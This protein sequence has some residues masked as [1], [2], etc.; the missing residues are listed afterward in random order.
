[1]TDR[2]ASRRGPVTTARIALVVAVAANGVIGHEGGL[3]WRVP[4]D[5]RHFRSL[6]MGKP[7]VMGRRTYQSIGGP[8]QGRD[9]I[10]V[11]RDTEF[12]PEGV[13]IA[14]SIAAALDEA[15][16]LARLRHVDEIMIIGGAMIY[17]ETLALAERLYVTEIHA[18]PA[19][20]TR[21]P[22]ID[23]AE[24]REISR[25]RF[26]AGARDDADYSLVVYERNGETE[27]D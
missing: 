11:T 13:F 25:R 8:L 26:V 3:P 4:S 9:N 5:L 2:A 27:A 18:T 1:M 10:V 12:A 15:E 20:D 22:R 6:T 7:V 24:W 17:A 21:F 23:A 16:R 14:A 19:G